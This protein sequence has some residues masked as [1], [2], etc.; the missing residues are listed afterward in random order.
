MDAEKKRVGI[1]GGTFNPIHN[2][3]LAIAEAAKESCNLDFVIFM[4]NGYPAY[5][6]RP[7][8]TDEDRE[9]MVKLALIG[10]EDFVY[11]D[12]EISQKN[13]TYTANTLPAFKKLHPDWEL[14][15]IVGSDSLC[16]MDKWYH[17][18][19]IFSEA[20]IVAACRDTE[21]MEQMEQY[22]DF[23]IAR[24]G[25]DIRLVHNALVPVSSTNI[26]EALGQGQSVAGLIPER[27]V[28]YIK[29]RGLYHGD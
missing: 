12:F 3:H 27:V 17:P 9:N 23:L 29:D 20:V 16:Y 15:Y 2:G 26:R 7:C 1:M 25:G 4:P 11:S 21:P 6:E 5:K 14:Y 28:Q 10:H 8:I 24:Y 22:R 19:I 18:E 13:V